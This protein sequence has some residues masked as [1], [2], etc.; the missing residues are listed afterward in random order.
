MGSQNPP[1]SDARDDAL[2]L[3]IAD[4]RRL[5]E[6]FTD[7]ASRRDADKDALIEETCRALSAHTQLEESLFYP[8]IQD[9]LGSGN[10]VEEARVEHDSLK[11]LISKLQ[12]GMLDDAARDATYTVMAQMALTH[13]HREERQLFPLARQASLDLDALGKKMR[14]EQANLREHPVLVEGQH[15]QA[16]AS[17]EHVG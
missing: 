8:A 4:H 13:M 3:L 7:F 10:L 12:S 17:H 14:D 1:G 11:Q 9:E 2:S 16:R 5:E 15:S 6:L